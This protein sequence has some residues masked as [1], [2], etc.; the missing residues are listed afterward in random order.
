MRLAFVFPGQGAQ[1]VGMGKDLYDNFA[2]ARKVFEEADLAT[3]YALSQLCFA[4]PKDKLNQTEFAQPA[5]LTSSVAAGEVLRE[6]GIEAVMVAGLSLGEYSALVYSQAL[7]LQEAIPLVQ[8]RARFM[9]AAVPAGEGAMAAVLGLDDQAVQMA[10]DADEGMVSIANYNCPGQYVISGRSEAVQRVA[11]QLQALGGRVMPLAVSVPSHSELMKPAAE[12]LRPHLEAVNWK[13]P[14][15]PVVSNVNAAPNPASLF[16]ELLLKQ[17]YSPIRW[18]QSIRYMMDQVD[19]FIEVG[20]GSTLS[21][22]IK[23]IDKNRVLG[24]VNDVN[25]LQKVI[26]KVNTK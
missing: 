13:E 4:G 19:Y 25:S 20:P 17:L 11:A 10:C 12:Q 8:L 14:L 7:S 6:H 22:L 18:E 23:K 9:Q 24:Q 1:Q 21:G 16:A 15:V 2:S 5:L 26:E 3:G